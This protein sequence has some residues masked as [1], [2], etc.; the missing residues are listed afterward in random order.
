MP[1]SQQI[2]ILYGRFFFP[3]LSFVLLLIFQKELAQYGGN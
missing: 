1:N 2:I 3:V